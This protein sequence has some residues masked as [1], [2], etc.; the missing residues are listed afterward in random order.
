MQQVSRICVRCGVLVLASA[1]LL[2]FATAPHMRADPMRKSL[3]PPEPAREFRGVWV[4]TVANTDWPSKP[5]LPVAQ[6]QS[7]LVA[8]MNR[9]AQLHLNAVIF[10]VRPACDA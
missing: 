10:Q 3:K 7:E 2:A 8:I 4:A 6:Q 5:G 9:A 1:C